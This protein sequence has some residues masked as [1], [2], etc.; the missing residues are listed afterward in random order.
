MQIQLPL[1]P[2]SPTGKPFQLTNLQLEAIQKGQALLDSG[3]PGVYKIAGLAGTGK[4]TIMREIVQGRNV[5]VAAFMGKAAAVLRKKGVSNAQTL[6]RTMYFWDDRR[7]VFVKKEANEIGCIGLAIDEGSTV[8]LDLWQDALSYQMPI[9]V[10][11]DHGQLEPVGDDARLMEKPDIVLE[12]IHRYEGSIAWYALQIRNGLVP[13]V[14]CIENTDECSVLPKSQ[15]MPDLQA[16]FSSNGRETTVL[17][18]FNRTRVATNAA[19]RKIRG[20]WQLPMY[21]GERLIALQNSRQLGTFNGQTLEVLK[22]LKES[23]H[24]KYG[25]YGVATVRFDD[26]RINNALKL[27]YGHLGKEKQI[28]WRRTPQD[29][30]IVDYGYCCTVHKFQGSEDRRILYI[31]EQC[32][33]WSPVRHRYTGVT[34]ASEGLSH[35]VD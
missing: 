31:D 12:E 19:I 27:W 21:E 4:T 20:F 13:R 2:T 1:E 5:K 29:M 9:I 8:G 14:G 11:G 15:F 23:V 18:G 32:D 35:Y 7:E 24:P 26:G 33:L 16:A 10:I 17:C 30:A 3:R 28:D 22:I 34:R 25:H 6:H